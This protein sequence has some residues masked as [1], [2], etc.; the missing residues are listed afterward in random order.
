MVARETYDAFALFG[1]IGG[2]NEIIYLLGVF[3]CSYWTKAASYRFAWHSLYYK[4]K[5]D[6]A[7]KLDVNISRIQ[8]LSYDPKT[9]NKF[10]PEDIEILKDQMKASFQN[11]GRV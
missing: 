7:E 2:V 6:Q 8:M 3:L 1:D 9:S 5:D 11:R 4:R 10:K